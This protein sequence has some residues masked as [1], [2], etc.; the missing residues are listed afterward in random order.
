MFLKSSLVFVFLLQLSTVVPDGTGHH[1]HEP[2]EPS[3]VTSYCAPGLTRDTGTVMTSVGDIDYQMYHVLQ[4]IPLAI[5]EAR[6]SI[7]QSTRDSNRDKGITGIA[8][9]LGAVSG[10][11][12]V[13]AGASGPTTGVVLGWLAQHSW[14]YGYW[15]PFLL[16]FEELDPGCGLEDFNKVLGDYSFVTSLYTTYS[17]ELSA[18]AYSSQHPDD[19]PELRA[20]YLSEFGR[21]AKHALHCITSK[22]GGDSAASKVVSLIDKY[23][24]MG[25]ERLQLTESLMS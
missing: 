11:L 8:C 9:L 14:G 13:T 7:I 18:G 2:H 4:T 6:S 1:H 19:R 15:G 5:Q 21:K 23:V 22:A 17:K 12:G 3:P 24:G 20:Y 10:G 25:L 16:D